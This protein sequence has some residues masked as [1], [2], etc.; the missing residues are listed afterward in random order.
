MPALP[1]DGRQTCT[2]LVSL[3]AAV[4][5][6]LHPVTVL[7]EEMPYVQGSGLDDWTSSQITEQPAAR[8]EGA[9]P[10]MQEAPPLRDSNSNGNGHSNGKTPDKA[11]LVS[12]LQGDILPKIQGQIADLSKQKELGDSAVALKSQ[13]QCVERDIMTLLSDAETDNISQIQSDAGKLQAEF[14]A[15]KTTLAEQQLTQPSTPAN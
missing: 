11:V 6:A 1:K 9:S 14:E 10:A 5:V 13:L 7:A 4:Q 8:A 15:I 3:L 2:Q 12:K